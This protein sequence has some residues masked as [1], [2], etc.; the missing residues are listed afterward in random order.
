MR[1]RL[2]DYVVTRYVVSSGTGINQLLKPNTPNRCPQCESG[3]PGSVKC[4][5][6]LN[7]Y[8][9][10][11]HG[12]RLG[13]FSCLSHRRAFTAYPPGYRPYSR[14][15]F[16]PVSPEGELRVAFA[17]QQGSRVISFLGT[18]FGPIQSDSSTV[19]ASSYSR[20]LAELSKILGISKH[21]TPRQREECCTMLGIDLSLVHQNARVLR[22]FKGP[23]SLIAAVV[24]KTLAVVPF[25]SIRRSFAKAAFY[26]GL[27]GRPIFCH[28]H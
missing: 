24:R 3:G 2:R 28:L 8:R 21:L 22:S 10:R 19:S 14:E 12:P 1:L 23:L 9:R 13:V 17:V 15:R 16:V 4:K 20:R 11:V 26:A 25:W 18:R 7:H 27:S 5:I 6:V